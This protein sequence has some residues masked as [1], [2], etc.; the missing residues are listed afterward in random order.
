MDRPL[1]LPAVITLVG[2]SQ[3][4]DS[5]TQVGEGQRVEILHEADNAYDSNAC[6]VRTTE[7][8][9]LGYLSRHLAPR[10]L[11]CG[12]A[13]FVGEV[14]ELR[15][16]ETWGLSIRVLAQAG[17]GPAA[18]GLEHQVPAPDVLAARD[19]VE[20][21]AL[22]VTRGGSEGSSPPV[23]A[24]SGREL[25]V[26]VRHEENKVVVRQPSGLEAAF[27]DELVRIAERA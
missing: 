8:E 27:P 2:V 13:H 12:G 20:G 5:V 26:F 9:T 24:K 23:F 25:G 6:V 11:A 21:L 18:A 15:I 14:A 22:A 17:V 19:G 4:Q 3:Y 7:G 16:G 1:H 10:L